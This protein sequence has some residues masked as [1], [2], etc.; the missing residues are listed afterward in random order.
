MLIAA[1]LL[2]GQSAPIDRYEDTAKKAD[3]VLDKLIACMDANVKVELKAHLLDAT[4]EG[5]TDAAMKDCASIRTEL[6][7]MMA[8][9]GTASAEG[10]GP[11]ANATDLGV[12]NDARFR[13]TY[14]ETV[15]RWLSEPGL[16]DSRLSLV[17]Q[18][19]SACVRQKAVSWSRR[20]D[21]A[22]AVAEA[23]VTACAGKKP[24]VRLAIS[25]GLKSK[26]LPATGL[27]QDDARLVDL[28]NQHALSWVIEERAK[29][30]PQK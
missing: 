26:K 11:A 2:I 19:W 22:K 21:E 9:Y 25:Y 16:A 23:A 14:I 27:Y 7:K 13:G 17:V 24:N 29:T 15:E 28:M 1:A 10:G 6:A 3:V 4:P 18:D 5:V 12:Q 8:P 20:K 30:L